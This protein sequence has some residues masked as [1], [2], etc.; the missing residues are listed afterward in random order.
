[1]SGET[2]SPEPWLLVSDI[3]DT[4]TGNRE[5]LNRLWQSLKLR[6]KGAKL[7]LNSS[8]PA[9]SVDRTLAEYFP[10]DFAPD[11]IITG[12]GT[13]IRLGRYWLESWR[14]QF[15]D[16]P[17][18]DIRKLVA[19]LGYAPHADVFQTEGKAS[20]SVPGKAEVER[21]LERLE[22]EGIQ[23]KYIYS[24]ASDLDIL[25]PGAGKDAAMRHLAGHLGI[26]ME[27]TVAA[28]DSGNDLALFEAAGKAIAVGNAREELLAAMP[29]EKTYHAS[30]NHAAGVLEGLIKLGL[31]REAAA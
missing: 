31:L 14:K 18:K 12:L 6:H 23:H 21:I 20:F 10:A 28:G 30:A 13:E 27:N 4:L 29:K 17:D 9:V 15:L 11:A 26:P 24:G 25:A 19:E 7:A 16:W 2:G 5:D 22:K 3:D 8:R 1:M